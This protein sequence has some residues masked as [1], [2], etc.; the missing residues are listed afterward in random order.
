[1]AINATG[2]AMY[3]DLTTD[4]LDIAIAKLFSGST[5]AVRVT[6]AYAFHTEAHDV[7]QDMQAAWADR[8]ASEHPG[9][10]E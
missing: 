7:I 4:E 3:A 5:A 2:P 10:A 8:F 6:G 9:L 1:M